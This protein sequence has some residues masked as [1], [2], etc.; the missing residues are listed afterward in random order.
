METPLFETPFLWGKID[1]SKGIYYVGWKPTSREMDDDDF[2][3][4]LLLSLQKFDDSYRDIR[5][6]LSDNTQFMYMQ[7]PNTEKWAA[8]IIGTEMIKNKIEKLAIVFPLQLFN[9]MA[10]SRSVSSINETEGGIFTT[11]NFGSAAKAEEWLLE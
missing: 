11:R 9:S 5:L 1:R 7:S 6:V 10:V 8:E 4:S 3:F 2:R